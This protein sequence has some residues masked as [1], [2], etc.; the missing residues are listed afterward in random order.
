MTTH[1]FD[2]I[3]AL[4]QVAGISPYNVRHDAEGDDLT[5]LKASIRKRG[6]IYR[7]I[8]HQDDSG[9][10]WVIEGGRRWRARREI[11]AEDGHDPDLTPFDVTVI[12]GAEPD[13]LIALSATGNIL[14]RAMHPVREYEAFAAIAAALPSEEAA[15]ETIAKE[16]GFSRKQVR[17]RLALG[18]LSPIIRAAWVAG[19][20]DAEAARAYAE[21][22]DLAAQEAAFDEMGESWMPASPHR[23]RKALLGDMLDANSGALRFIGEDAYRAAGGEVRDSLFSEERR[24]SGPLVRKLAHEKLADEAERIRLAEGWGFYVLPGDPGEEDYEP[25]ADFYPDYL[26][27]EEARAEAIKLA[28]RDLN[29]HDPD[30]AQKIAALDAEVDAIF[31]RA[32]MRAL[33]AAERLQMGIFV[34]WNFRGA[35]EIDRALVAP[36]GSEN[37]DDDSGEYDDDDAPLRPSREKVAAKRPDEGAAQAKTPQPEPIGKQLRAV[38]DETLSGA[39]HDATTRNVNAALAFA[40]AALGGAWGNK[41]LDLQMHARRGWTPAHP[42][43]KSIAHKSFDQALAAA[44]ATPLADLTTAFCELIAASI[45]PARLPELEPSLGLVKALA[46]WTGIESDIKAAFDADAYFRAATKDAALAMIR[47]TQGPASAAESR[48]LKKPQLVEHATL[49]AKDFDWLPPIL[50]QALDASPSPLAGEGGARSAT[51]EGAQKDERTTAKAMLDAIEADS[52][53]TVDDE[54]YDPE[55][56]DIET[57]NPDPPLLNLTARVHEF[58]ALCCETGENRDVKASLLLASYNAWAG[59]RDLPTATQAGLALALHECGFTKHRFT[60]GVCYLGLG[61]IEDRSEAA[62]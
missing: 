12:V 45:D 53:G 32:T 16:F 1:T 46:G 14:A 41:P 19:D 3:L 29:P 5:S 17:Q 24:F 55:P 42:L 49:I 22:P 36:A 11:M 48:D 10:Y 7:P 30:D 38:L 21:C 62:E 35:L 6:I 13:E 52:A 27:E 26:A 40:V 58:I 31:A 60:R 2:A 54:F 43:L 44:A 51:D 34:S 61:L 56:S 39:L 20:L 18:A 59:L 50:R 9:H 28:L 23:I 8:V 15:I 4:A 37:A 57:P 25:L 33:P 47:D